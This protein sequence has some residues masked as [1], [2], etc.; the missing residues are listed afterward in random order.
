M[1]QPTTPGDIAG[2]GA[3]PVSCLVVDD[4]PRLR[5]V[6]CQLLQRMGFECR[7]AANGVEALVQLERQ[8]ADLITSDMRMPAMD[9]K[10]F[11]RR[12]HERWP[13]TAVVMVTA[14]A[15]VQLAVHCLSGG[16]MDYLTKPFHLEEVEARVRQVLERRRLLLESRTH[17]QEL[18]RR[19]AEQANRIE[20][21]FLA[22]MQALADALELKDPYT[23]GHSIRVS[24]YSC[25]IARAMELDDE[26]IRQIEL[27]GHLHDIGKIGVHET[28]LTKQGKLTEEEYRHIMEHPVLGWRILK[29][30]LA[31]MPVAL[32]V[33][34]FH[35]ER[36]DGRGVP[37]GL[38]GD[39]I[40]LEARI[41]AVADALDAMMSERPYRKSEMHL[42]D[43]LAELVA[44]AGRQFDR[45]V[46]DAT[47]F[48]ID[49]G[50]LAL[51]PRVERRR[52]GAVS[53]AA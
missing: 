43:A 32:N 19:V 41:A 42:G 23:R 8:P 4:E 17:R 35:H 27:G 14:V 11:L 48:A 31:D 47:L 37:D 9:G 24:L 50:E 25:A 12:V 22:G 16:A 13:D 15:D 21:T 10:E 2:S 28:I 7:A 45:K 53:G 1:Q 38:A 44:N 20:R 36:V 39:R 6:L 52:Q 26:T 3:R 29:P 30:L 18:E 40:P 46:V 34:R 49:H 51:A 33:V 5:H